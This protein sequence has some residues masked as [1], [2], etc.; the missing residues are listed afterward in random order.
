M[1][2]TIAAPTMAPMAAYSGLEEPWRSCMKRTMHSRNTKERDAISVG[3][4]RRAGYFVMSTIKHGAAP[5]AGPA[6]L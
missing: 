1:V 3:V 2:K 5:S 6:I 4:A